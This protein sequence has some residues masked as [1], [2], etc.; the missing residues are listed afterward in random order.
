MRARVLPLAAV[1][2]ASALGACRAAGA[3][4]AALAGVVE[5]ESPA[6]PGSGEP[7]LAA[8]PDGRVYLTWVERREE[9]GHALR[10]AVL[11]GERWS[12]PGTIATGD[13]WF[14]N[15][16]DFPSL[17]V[18]PGGGLAAHWLQKSGPGT[19]AYDVRI[20]RSGD[21][22]RTWSAPVTPHRDGTQTE[23]GFVSMWPEAGDSV[24]AVWLDGRGFTAD[25]H[26]PANEMMLMYTRIGPGG[27]PG[28][29]HLLDDRICD[30]CQTSAVVTSRGPLVVY[31]DRSPEEIR[32]I[33]VV[34]RVDG[35]WTPPA[36]V[37]RD[38]WEIAACPVNGPFASA[39]GERVAVAWFTAA[40]DTARVNVAFS[41]D[42]GATFAP[43]V[44]VDGG[45]PVGRVAVQ[46]LDDGSALVSWL[47]RMDDDRAAV[48]VRRVSRDGALGAPQTV[49]ESSG[50][51]SSG[52]PRMVRAGDRVVFAWTASGDPSRV[53]VAAAR[54]DRGR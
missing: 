54:V 4:E 21:G 32:D 43:P 25:G 14:V 11:D 19:Y 33:S 49:A 7:N 42:A 17:A 29:E 9:G 30:C 39:E 31:R 23:H 2:A 22:G 44:R 20:A 37:H 13:D 38:G 35:A 46:L 26:D 5:I 52:F 3:D 48:R 10:F 50:A 24:A 40:R 51:R 36:P 28:A 27:G 47:E 15:W 53:R 8:G 6:A 34:R 12:E 1:L 18:L 41:D 45:A 16:A